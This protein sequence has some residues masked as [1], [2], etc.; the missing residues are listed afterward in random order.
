[1]HRWI[2][3]GTNHNPW[4]YFLCYKVINT[5]CHIFYNIIVNLRQSSTFTLFFFFFLLRNLVEFAIAIL[6]ICL[7]WKFGWILIINE[8]RKRSNYGLMWRSNKYGPRHALAV[9]V[10]QASMQNTLVLPI[11][12][13]LPRQ[14][15]TR[16]FF[17]QTS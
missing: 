9:L 10:H 5:K 4:S 17:V 14:K 6:S 8:L 3:D 1:M 7:C 11:A 16:V 13:H 2:D 15:K 12:Q